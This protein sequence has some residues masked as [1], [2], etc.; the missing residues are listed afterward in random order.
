MYPTQGLP[1]PA[2][3]RRIEPIPEPVPAEASGG[4]PWQASGPILDPGAG[5]PLADPFEEHAAACP[6]CGENG[7]GCDPPGY[8][9]QPEP[10]PSWFW[11]WLDHDFPFIDSNPA[12]LDPNHLI[13]HWSYTNFVLFG[14]FQGFKGPVDEGQGSNFGFHEGFN[15]SI[16][17]VQ[18]W[19]FSH[20]TGAQGVHSD[21][22]GGSGQ[23]AHRNQFFLTSGFYRR[24]LNG[25]G[26]Q[27]GVVTD[28]LHDDWYSKSDLDQIRAEISLVGKVHEI[29]LMGMFHTDNSNKISPITGKPIQ[30]QAYDQYLAYYRRRVHGIGYGRL[31]AGM[32]NDG[33]VIFG[34]DGTSPLTTHWAFQ[35]NFNFIFPRGSTLG[36]A[37]TDQYWTLSL[38]LVYYPGYHTALASLNPFRPLFDVADNTSFLINQLGR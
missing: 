3:S 11:Y 17:L 10:R 28:Y 32:D 38:N 4:A 19:G 15:W 29:G 6:P 27:A 18:K 31:W 26:W 25:R 5:G 37:L 13:N 16:P 23:D 35:S 9:A 21:L 1:V 36:D 33:D 20:Q 14:G 2:R 34:G 22:S 12:H 24:P 7:A 30:W 8:C